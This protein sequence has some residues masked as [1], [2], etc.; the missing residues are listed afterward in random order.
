[1]T[2]SPAG[3]LATAALALS[4]LERP[5][6]F[7]S[8]IPDLETYREDRWTLYAQRTTLALHRPVRVSLRGL[9]TYDFEADARSQTMKWMVEPFYARYLSASVM[10][11]DLAVA[12]AAAEIARREPA[13]WREVLRGETTDLG[14]YVDRA[15][16]GVRDTVRTVAE[17]LSGAERGDKCA[18][19][20]TGYHYV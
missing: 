12:G 15:H 10:L 7:T 19:V 16:A 2:L 14:L 8:A 13:A 5:S 3:L 9:V 17:V 1:V 4:A 20:A 18:Y 11:R 6:S